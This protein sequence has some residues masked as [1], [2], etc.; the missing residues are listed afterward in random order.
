[1]NKGGKGRLLETVSASG[2][3]LEPICF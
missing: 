1:M 2:A 3:M